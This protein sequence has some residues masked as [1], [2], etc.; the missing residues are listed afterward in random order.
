MTFALQRREKIALA[1]ALAAGIALGVAAD[2]ARAG[3]EIKVGMA[4][5]AY[6]PKTVQARV[7][8]VI[9]FTNDDFENHWVYVPT[10]GHLISRGTQKPGEDFK[11]IL[12]K[13]GRFDVLCAL[14]TSMAM[15]VAVSK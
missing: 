2:T 1:F 3:N 12:G 15:T 7:G 11:L 14:H 4:G 5:T 10:H 8:D 13:D 6:A 9:N